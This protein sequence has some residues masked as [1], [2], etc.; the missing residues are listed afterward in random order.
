M[1]KTARATGTDNRQKI[2][3]TAMGL[4]A[5]KGVDQTSLAMIARKSGL[6]KGTLY[7]YYASKNDLIFD[8][9]DRHMEWITEAILSTGRPKNGLKTWESLLYAYFDVLLSARDRSRLHLYLI[10]E[11]VSGNQ[12]L[13]IR[14]QKTYAHWFSLI[15][16]TSRQIQADAEN[17]RVKSKFLVA[18]VEGFILQ[19]LLEVEKTDIRDMVNLALKLV[20][21]G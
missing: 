16:D 12:A 2:L 15:D 4:I 19:E 7:Y 10:R 21:S 14:F 3:D 13:K 6:S 18:V 11:A 8:I 20:D 17:I 9:T 5:E 1:A